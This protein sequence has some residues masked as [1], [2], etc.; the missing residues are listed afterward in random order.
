MAR[1]GSKKRKKARQERAQKKPPKNTF[2]KVTFPPIQ[3]RWPDAL[4]NERRAQ[5]EEH[6]RRVR[7][8]YH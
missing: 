1:K 3:A 7:E 2:V 8:E 5:D 6:L 4:V